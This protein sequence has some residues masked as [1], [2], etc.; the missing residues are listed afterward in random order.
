M[1][2]GRAGNVLSFLL[3]QPAEIEKLPEILKGKGKA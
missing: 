3:H 2:S 1:E